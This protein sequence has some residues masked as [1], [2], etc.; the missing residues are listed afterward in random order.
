[1]KEVQGYIMIMGAAFF[2]GV[3]ATGAK[4]LLNQKIDTVLIVQSRVSITCVLL[5]AF[6]LLFKRHLLVVALRDLW[7]FAMLGV[8]G[9]AGANFTYYFTIKES[10]VATGILI[11]YTAPLFVMS[12]SVLAREERF[13]AIKLSAAL[14]ALLGCFLAVGGVEEI[15]ITPLG[16]LTGAGSVFCFAFMSIYT[17]HVL[18]KYNVWTVTFYSIAFASI[19]WLMV[20]PPWAVAVAGLSWNA[21]MGL[22]VLAVASVLIP[23]SLFFGGLR[24][25]VPSRAVITSTF[26][27]IVAIISAALVL[28]EFLEPVQI[29]G[30]TLVMG[31]IILLQVRREAST[32]ITP[33]TLPQE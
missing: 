18:Q 3:S 30:A 22:G 28:G 21:W 5:L 26:E 11:Q 32:P 19:F 14:I 24:F 23:H 4:F 20:N 15:K 2:W 29:I 17:R 7:Q 8:L 6:Y 1:M 31:A 13:T 27:P 12:Y 25:V 10:S 9:I 16:L 33:S